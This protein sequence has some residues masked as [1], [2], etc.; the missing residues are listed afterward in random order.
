MHFTSFISEYDINMV[1]QLLQ[2]WA[3]LPNSASQ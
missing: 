3:S 2:L 1:L